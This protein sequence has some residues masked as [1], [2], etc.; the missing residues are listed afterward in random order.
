MTFGQNRIL[1]EDNNTTEHKNSNFVRIFQRFNLNN[2]FSFQFINGLQT[3][4]QLRIS[5]LNLN[6]NFF[7]YFQCL[8][9]LEL[10]LFFFLWNNFF[11]LFR[12]CFFLLNS[13]QELLSLDDFLL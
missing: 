1:E 3:L 13:F 11:S 8:L 9:S 2:L 10:S 6:L 7:G 4:S 12:L 5:I